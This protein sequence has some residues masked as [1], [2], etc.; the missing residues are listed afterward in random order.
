MS[1]PWYD[2]T[3]KLEAFVPGEQSM[4][5]PTSPQGQVEPLDPGIPRTLVPIQ[6]HNFAPRIGIAYSPDGSSGVLGK[7]FG[8][9]GKTSIRAGY[10]VFYQ[11]IEDATSFYESGD[12]PY[13]QDWI[14]PRSPSAR[15]TLCRSGDRAFRRSK[16]SLPLSP[17]E[18]VPSASLYRL[19]LGGRWNRSRAPNSTTYRTPKTPYSQQF[20]FSVQRQFGG[21][22][23]A[24][25]SYV[26]TMG[27]HLLTG[28]EANPGNQ[29]QC[30]FLNNP[31]NCRPRRRS[32]TCGPGS[33]ENEYIDVNKV[34]LPYHSSLFDVDPLRVSMDLA[35]MR[36]TVDCAL[37]VQLLAGKPEE[38][39]QVRQLPGCL[40]VLES[41]G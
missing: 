41:Y 25:V 3:N 9:A 17:N 34:R 19:Q 29:A 38:P 10:G 37:L 2:A 33:E 24:S 40:Y 23:V 26:G 15:Y 6:Y 35:P 14:G 36:I 16:I 32:P 39:G 22:T 7:L 12:A 21:A 18:C 4:A 11:G 20:E 13:G 28:A 31:A 27:N 8:G 1:T 5:F 30:L